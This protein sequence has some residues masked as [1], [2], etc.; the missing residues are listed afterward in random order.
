MNKACYV[1]SAVIISLL[2]N[3]SCNLLNALFKSLPAVAVRSGSTLF[4][5]INAATASNGKYCNLSACLSIPLM[6]GSKWPHSTD[7]KSLGLE[8]VPTSSHNSDQSDSNGDRATS[9]QDIPT[10]AM[11]IVGQSKWLN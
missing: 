3:I 5:S 4:S 10:V 6:R 2:T 8:Y 7:K 9:L 11:G 1:A